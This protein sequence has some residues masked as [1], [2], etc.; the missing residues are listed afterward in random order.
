MNK[1]GVTQFS[2]RRPCIMRHNQA[3]ARPCAVTPFFFCDFHA[4]GRDLS[5]ARLIAA[6]GNGRGVMKDRQQPRRRSHFHDHA[7]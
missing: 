7:L 5:A 6:D 4:P 2:A 3:K 1:A